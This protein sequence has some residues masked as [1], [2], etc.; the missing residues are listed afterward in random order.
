[1]GYN[2]IC[3]TQGRCLDGWNGLLQSLQSY[4]GGIKQS[5]LEGSQRKIKCLLLQVSNTRVK[6]IREELLVL[7]APEDILE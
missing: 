6:E 3:I 1:M 2:T 5:P 7:E 4:L